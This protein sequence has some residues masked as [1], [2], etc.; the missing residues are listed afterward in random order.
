M[1]GEMDKI[2]YDFV[3][4][5]KDTKALKYFKQEGLELIRYLG[6][7]ISLWLQYRGK[8]LSRGQSC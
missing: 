4:F 5:L 1:I 3:G 6:L 2:I 7:K 8:Y